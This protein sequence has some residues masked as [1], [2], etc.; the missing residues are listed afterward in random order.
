ME[1]NVADLF[2]VHDKA[3]K[4][5]PGAMPR[6][7]TGAQGRLGYKQTGRVT[8]WKLYDYLQ[9]GIIEQGGRAYVNG[10]LAALHIEKTWFTL[11][12][13][14]LQ[15]LFKYMID[16]ENEQ[17]TN[18]DQEIDREVARKCLYTVSKL[19]AE[20][21]GPQITLDRANTALGDLPRLNGV[22]L[23]SGQVEDFNPLVD[24]SYGLYA[25]TE[26]KQKWIERWQKF[27]TEPGNDPYPG[28]QR[29]VKYVR[30]AESDKQRVSGLFQKLGELPNLQPSELLIFERKDSSLS[31]DGR[32][33]KH[34]I[35]PL[36]DYCNRSGRSIAANLDMF[37]QE[38]TNERRL[39]V[40]LFGVKRAAGNSVLCY[41]KQADSKKLSK[42]RLYN[43][44][45][46]TIHKNDYELITGAVRPVEPVQNIVEQQAVV[47]PVEQQALPAEGPTV[48]EADTAMQQ[49]ISE[50]PSKERAMYLTLLTNHGVAV[51]MRADKKRV[52]RYYR[53]WLHTG[54][55]D[56]PLQHA[57]QLM[58]WI[59]EHKSID[60]DWEH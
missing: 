13:R 37:N 49:Y 48:A 2:E 26:S 43:I 17:T 54:P 5:P 18:Y 53:D 4:A 15:E 28:I 20:D 52:K 41:L 55:N 14:E 36:E 40:Q 1:N 57:K 31:E 59:A 29:K 56:D 27:V 42:V 22:V 7:R 33:L 30:E 38:G 46:L 47:Q 60:H 12:K 24:I 23:S 19:L 21:F 58:D 10:C 50:F 35:M 34:G 6:K 16:Q 25:Y 32:L 11:S 8:R 45:R 51:N 3:H 44:N 39:D 9:Q